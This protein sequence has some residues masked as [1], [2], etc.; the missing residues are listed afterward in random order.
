[1]HVIVQLLGV[2]H[3]RFADLFTFF[4]GKRLVFLSAVGVCL[5]LPQVFLDLVPTGPLLNL[6][7]FK[8]GFT[9][10]QLEV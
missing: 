2:L 3:E 5:R 10:I 7:F 8:V 4:S 9:R 1:M 6:T